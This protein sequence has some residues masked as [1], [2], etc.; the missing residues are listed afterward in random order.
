[1]PCSRITAMPGC[2]FSQSLESVDTIGPAPQL[3]SDVPD[4]Q[5][6]LKHPEAVDVDGD[7]GAGAL[8]IHQYLKVVVY[9]NRRTRQH[10][11]KV[12]CRA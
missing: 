6:C 5:K 7:V 10:T 4:V 9:G 2:S 8:L 1:M 3:R 12:C 11:H